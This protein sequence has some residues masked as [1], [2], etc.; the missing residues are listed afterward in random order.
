MVDKQLAARFIQEAKV[1]VVCIRRLMNSQNNMR[2]VPPRAVFHAQQCEGMALNSAMLRTCG[3]SEDE[4]AGGAAHDLID[5][6]KRIRGAEANT[7][8]QK[9]AAEVPITELD[10]DW[11]KRAYLA[12]RYPKP[13]RWGVPSL[14]Y[15]EADADRALKMAEVFVK[16]AE[17][18]ED[19][20][21]PGKTRRKYMQYEEAPTIKP[22]VDPNL[23]APPP[24]PRFVPPPSKS[25]SSS[26]APPPGYQS[27]QAA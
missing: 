6:I 10:V 23:P 14:L 19:L 17:E 27:S 1:E 3:V 26:S 9:R 15:D 2:I 20:P 22:A 8:E 11:L 4:V 7:V 16:W 25:S 13:G 5:F 21:D 12:A 18:V 24:V